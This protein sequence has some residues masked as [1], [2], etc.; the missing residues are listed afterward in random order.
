MESALAPR[1]LRQAFLLV[2]DE[3]APATEARRNAFARI[4]ARFG[5]YYREATQGRGTAESTLL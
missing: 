1:L 3:T 5:P 4:R 2:A